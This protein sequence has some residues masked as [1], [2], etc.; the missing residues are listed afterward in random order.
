MTIDKTE[1]A[2]RQ[3]ET[4]IDLYFDD[5]DSLSVHTLAFASL[6][7]LFDLYPHR[8]QDGFAAQLDGILQKEGWK[9]MSGVANFLK[10]ADRDPDAL[11]AQHH[12][13]QGMSIIGLATLLYRR[14]TGDLSLK[15]RAFDYWVEE[16]GYEN[17]EIEELDTDPQRVQAFAD[18]RAQIRALPHAEMMAVGKSQYQFFLT[19]FEKL[20]GMARQ[21]EIE[22][23]SLTELLDQQIGT[24]T[25]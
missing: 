9:A 19:N 14:I 16:L 7:V 2:R 4:A 1:A 24:V 17:L 5:A 23:L 25:K 20:Q 8:N 15:M 13:Q 21:A 18:H 11:L 3:L 6:K 22:G 10:H 12:P